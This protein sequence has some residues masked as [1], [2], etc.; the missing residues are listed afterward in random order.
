MSSGRQSGQESSFRQARGR[1]GHR[2]SGDLG[3]QFRHSPCQGEADRAALRSLRYVQDERDESTA[4]HGGFCP[5]LQKGP[6]TGDN[7]Y[8]PYLH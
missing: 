8:L 3:S 5:A 7:R 4:T 1:F 6:R 2:S